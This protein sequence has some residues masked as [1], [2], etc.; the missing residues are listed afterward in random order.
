MWPAAR[1]LAAR[2]KF[3]C[4]CWSPLLLQ[5]SKVECSLTENPWL[6]F[7]FHQNGG[8]LAR[9]VL[10]CLV[11]LD[12][13]TTTTQHNTKVWPINW[14]DWNVRLNASIY[15]N[16]LPYC[17]NELHWIVNV[18]CVLIHMYFFVNWST[19]ERH[20]TNIPIISLVHN[21]TYLGSQKSKCWTLLY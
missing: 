5:C 17:S 1:F 18:V 7:G 4:S 20:E 13:M 10:K 19:T 9:S 15:Y 21:C 6:N 12:I 14:L 3:Y 11:P 16:Y 8:L 2:Q